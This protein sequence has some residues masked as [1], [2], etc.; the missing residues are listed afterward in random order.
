MGHR[1]LRTLP[2]GELCRQLLD[3]LAQ[4]TQARRAGKHG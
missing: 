1:G 2:A 3:E 4:A